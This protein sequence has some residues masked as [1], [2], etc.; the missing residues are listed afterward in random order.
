MRPLDRL[1]SAELRQRLLTL[2]RDLHRQ[3]ELSLEEE[4]TAA[5]LY[6]ELA[7]LRP[8]ALDRVAGTGVIARLRGTEPSAPTVV[9][10]GDIDALPI[11]EETD[12]TYKSEVAGVM[13]ACGHDVH[14]AWTVGAA[15]LLA[16]RPARGDVLILLQ[17]AE[18]IGL[19]ARAVLESGALDDAATIFG[20]H[21]D[22]RY[23]VGR[24]VV[25]SGP[26]AAAADTFHIELSGRGAHAARPHEG[27]DPI[28]GAGALVTALQTI[29]SRRLPPGTPAVVT[30][31]MLRAGSAPNVIPERAS[32]SG[33]L[34]SLDPETREVLHAALHRIAERTADGHGL[35]ARVI[36][37]S[38]PPPL[39]NPEEPAGWARHAVAAALGDGALA[40]MD[41]PNMGGE[42]F[43]Y[44]LERMPGCFLRIGAR[45][46]RGAVIPAHTSRFYAADEAVLVGAAVLAE[47]ARVAAASLSSN[48]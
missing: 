4:R 27:I 35:E 7:D 9:L 43:A 36:V 34:R 1:F 25:Q 24:V 20:A 39:V 40:R 46:E 26:L 11:Q 33:T 2:R 38:G 21:V 3:P 37:E 28:P 32:L 41:A 17:P 12:L 22:R 5:R 10:R 19:G 48:G 18:E 6:D 29:V 8:A 31:G 13:H 23:P 15:H 47:T 14:A 16:A 45:E 44:Y 42:D 30:V